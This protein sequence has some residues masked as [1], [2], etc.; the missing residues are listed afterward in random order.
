MVVCLI[1]Q[2]DVS[3]Q[4]LKMQN[5]LK[6]WYC[7]DS[8]QTGQ[9][10]K[11]FKL[12]SSRRIKFE[13]KWPK[14][15]VH[16][17]MQGSYLCAAVYLILIT[18]LFGKKQ[19]TTPPVIQTQHSTAASCRSQIE[20]LTG[21]TGRIHTWIKQRFFSPKRRNNLSRAAGWWWLGTKRWTCSW[22]YLPGWSGPLG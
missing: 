20:S 14:T 2:Q 9:I 7:N 18:Y 16:M 21:E 22:W 5:F 17:Q 11:Q 12:F 3:Y 1:G 6:Q 19:T 15:N 4:M 13:T 8:Q 10:F